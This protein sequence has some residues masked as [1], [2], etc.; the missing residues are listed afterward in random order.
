[1]VGIANSGDTIDLSQLPTK[2]GMEHSTITLTN[3]EIVVNQHDLTLQGPDPGRGSITISPSNANPTRVLSHAGSGLL[4]INALTVANGYLQTGANDALGGCI[5][6]NGD[7]TFQNSIAENCTAIGL[8]AS[9]GG[10][11]AYGNLSIVAST[12]SGNTAL[13]NSSDGRGGGVFAEKGLAVKYSTL[14]NNHASTFGGGA[15]TRSSSPGYYTGIVNSTINGNTAAYCGGGALYTS[16]G[17]I[18]SDSTISGNTAGIHETGGV[19]VLG[20]VAISNSTIGFNVGDGVA[21][22]G[23]QSSLTLQSSIVA[24]NVLGSDNYDLN[25]EIAG[26]TILGNNNLVTSSNV[27]LQGVVTVSSDPKLGSLQFNGGRTRT[28]A[29]LSGSPA[30]GTGNNTG[31]FATDQ[32]GH[33]YPRTGPNVNTDIGAFQFDSIFAHDFEF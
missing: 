33:G 6:S 31:G 29:L 9:G 4:T 21:V 25:I 19:C 24:K 23:I 20:D 3:G 11:F 17:V 28:H 26:T 18:I 12:V 13:A 2:C 14:S 32:R 1:M 30:I 8:N 5:K 22:W 7:I 27:N 10:I 16:A 15:Y